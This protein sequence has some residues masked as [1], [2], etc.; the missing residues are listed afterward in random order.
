MATA[1]LTLES[2]HDVMAPGFV[3]RLLRRPLAI[4]ALV[5]LAVIIV[6]CATASLTLPD[7]P[8]T[9]DLTVVKLGP[10]LQHLLGTDTLGRDV[11]ARVMYGGRLSLVGVLEAVAVATAIGVTFGMVAGYF[12]G[13]IDRTISSVVDLVL[14]LPTI[15]ILLSVLTL[16]K[17]DI[18]VAMFGFGVLGSAGKVRVIRSATLAVREELY[19]DAARVSGVNNATIIL[20]HVLPRIT[21]PAIVQMSLFAALALVVQTGLAYNG[22]GVQLPAPSWGGMIF[23]ASTALAGD[24]W[25][26]V[27][28]GGVVALTILALGLLGDAA[29][30]AAAEGWAPARA[31]STRTGEP[32]VTVNTS[33]LQPAPN[34]TLSV[35]GLTIE[36]VV[37]H[38]RHVFVSDVSFDVQPGETL[39]IV[40]ESGCGKTL[41]AMSLLGLLPAGF[42][43]VAGRAWLLGQE[44]P[45]QDDNAMRA[46]RGSA[47]AMI[48]QDP[49]ASLDPAARVGDLV[50]EVV[51]A[52]STRSRRDARAHTLELFRAV[53]LKDPESVFNRY[54]HQLSGGMAQRVGIAMALAGGP[55]L[56]IADEPT[57]ALDVTI[58][59]EI[60]D[61]LRSLRVDT[62]MA[63]LLVTHDWGVVAD[64]CDRA[65]VLYSGEIVEFAPVE[66]MFVR[67]SH[68][69]TADLMQ[70]NP[71][72]AVPGH[73]LAAISG[74]VAPR[75]V[76]TAGCQ[77]A[78]RCRFAIEACRTQSIR[79]EQ[80][81]GALARCIR[82]EELLVQVSR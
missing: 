60:L 45:L 25:L 4:L 55:R 9:Q 37:G 67:P 28:T 46:F 49:I 8:L 21:G 17:G 50:T 63:M 64:T 58:Q 16:F 27:P 78:P 41:T 22:L 13:W 72:R 43:V 34:A 80:H 62:G 77:Y 74:M 6:A 42:H 82:S 14:S 11:L 20:R 73:R 54:P 56:L 23:E 3:H 40:G 36:Q 81:N 30:D 39:G 57:T 29:R 68:P 33:T 19:I 31:G 5:Y 47:M 53:R 59:A 70:S 15:I 71:E 48:F 61:L 18:F 51:R 65:L 44:L 12:G 52:H 79:L 69:Y 66:P 75:P 26:L 38:Q 24:P 32:V 10:S 76:W 7:G 1:S 2:A 35:R